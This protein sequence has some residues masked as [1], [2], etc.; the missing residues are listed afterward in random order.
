ME[1]IGLTGFCKPQRVM[2]Q[3]RQAGFVNVVCRNFKLPI[4]SWPK[5]PRLRQAGLFGLFNL[6][7]GLEGLSLKVFTELLG[8]SLQELEVLLMECRREIKDNTIHSYW[9]V[10]VHL[11]S[12]DENV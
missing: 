10:Y 2:D 12:R 11:L 3:M 9:P 1:R 7:D 4:G 8:Y 5:D 6:L